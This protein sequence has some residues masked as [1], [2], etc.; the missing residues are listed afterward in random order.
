MATTLE[1]FIAASHITT[2]RQSRSSWVTTLF[3][4][5]AKAASLAWVMWD[6]AMNSWN[7][8]K[9][10]ARRETTCLLHLR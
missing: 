10:S 6:W 3:T 7:T 2:S 4:R 9:S 1:P 8:V 5:V